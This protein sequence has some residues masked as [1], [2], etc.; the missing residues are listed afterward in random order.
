MPSIKTET[1]INANIKLCF[2]LARDVAI[3]EQSLDRASLRAVSGK[4]SGILE[5]GEWVSWEEEHFGF[6]QHLTLKISEL[7][8]P[9]YFVEEMVEGIFE[10]FRNEFHFKAY[11]E[12]TLL[13][14]VLSFE[15][16]YGFLGKMTKKVI[17]R[18]YAK[19]LLKSR[20]EYLKSAIED[21]AKK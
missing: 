16:P 20:V 14:N 6:L 11:G 12:K 13:V 2:D 10:S 17:M 4:T 3:H 5:L 8:K 9:N 1:L 18:N 19:S 21:S 7:E 15:L